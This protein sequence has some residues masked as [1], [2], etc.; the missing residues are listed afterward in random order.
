MNQSTPSVDQS[1]FIMH[2]VFSSRLLR[3]LI[4]L[5]NVRFSH[6]LL[7]LFLFHSQ[8]TFTPLCFQLSRVNLK[9]RGHL[10]IIVVI[11]QSFSKAIDKLA[12][13]RYLD[14]VL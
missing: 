5:G 14:H 11:E 13:A 10:T 1:E 2:R 12:I 4:L 9:V 8:T 6:L 3:V 7:L